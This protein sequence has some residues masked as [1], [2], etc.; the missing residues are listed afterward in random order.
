MKEISETGLWKAA[1]IQRAKS[2]QLMVDSDEDSE[3][4]FRLSEKV[5]MVD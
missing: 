4:G 3:V 1:F 2:D 5:A